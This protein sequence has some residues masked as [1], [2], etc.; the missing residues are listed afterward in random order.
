MLGTAACRI[1]PVVAGEA[2]LRKRAQTPWRR[3]AAVGACLAIAL[4]MTVVVTASASASCTRPDNTIWTGTGIGPKQ[5][6]TFVSFVKVEPETPPGSEVLEFN[7]TTSVSG[8]YESLPESLSGAYFGTVTCAGGESFQ[9]QLSGTVGG[10]PVSVG[11]KYS[12][13]VQGTQASGTYENDRG[14]Q[15]T[16]A[17]SLFATAQSAGSEPGDVEMINPS[18]STATSLSADSAQAG[19]P[20]GVVAPVGS[21][22]YGVTD[23]TPGA[24]FDITFKLPPG[25]HPTGAFKLVGGE[26][27]PYPADKTKIDGDQI[28]LEVL[29][30]G[31]YD[32]NPELGVV[33]DPVVPVAPEVPEFGRCQ[34]APSEKVGT[35]TVYLGKYTAS[36]CLLRS[37]TDTGKYEWYP[38][39]VKGHFETNIKPTTVAALETTTKA[40]V[41]CSGERST[42]EVTG[43]KSVGSVVLSFT[44]CQ[45]GGQE[46][47]TSGLPGGEVQT[48]TLEGVLGIE[49]VLIKLG[50]ETRK[51]ALD[52]YPVGKTGAFVEYTCTGSSPT[53]LSG[54]VIGPVPTNKMFTT[55]AVKD[56]QAKGKQK[57]ERFEGGESDVLTNSLNQQV[58]LSLSAIQTN[59]EPFEINA[60]Y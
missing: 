18:S 59:E 31:I 1:E 8:K 19:L 10:F 11:V 34:K 54:S 15:G 37:A 46:C 16:W 22:S 49:K 29:D 58:G 26:Y 7:G 23:L 12:G 39:V 27:L 44:G 50:K 3:L 20:E 53:V 38:G 57:P 2:A 28:T 35:K 24:L 21:L 43:A 48:T 41:T 30:N 42:G 56:L 13:S 5:T 52:L 47:T 55:A 17:A 45:S 32:E 4:V 36:S 14:E 25:S 33:T 40:K 9:A 51:A 6:V 60:A